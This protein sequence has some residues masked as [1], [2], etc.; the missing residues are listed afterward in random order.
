MVISINEQSNSNLLSP[1][2]E[3]TNNN[4]SDPNSQYEIYNDLPYGSPHITADSNYWGSTNTQHVDSAIYD[5]FDDATKSVVYYTP[6][7]LNPIQV[8]TSCAPSS[9]NGIPSINQQSSSALFPNP[10]S[11]YAVIRFNKSLHHA[12]LKVYNVYGQMVKAMD[13]VDG[14]AILI[15]RDEMPNGFYIY[16]VIENQ[17]RTTVGKMVV[18]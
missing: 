16:E 18:E 10:F 5:Y 12:T 3:I 8:D 15:N 9:E 4:L 6:I 14:S 13:P 2:L 1:S 7:L 11:D 17:Q